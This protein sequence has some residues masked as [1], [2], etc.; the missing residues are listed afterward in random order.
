MSCTIIISY[1]Y[2]W[3]IK[4]LIILQPLL[5]N[6]STGTPVHQGWW[7]VELHSIGVDQESVP[8]MS[9]HLL[10]FASYL[11]G[12]P[13]H[14]YSRRSICHSFCSLATK[15]IHFDVLIIFYSQLI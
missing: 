9:E 8:K 4:W 12:Y 11:E 3:Y 15:A 7:M 14:F 1:H 13:L 2:S 10:E 6:P 5:G